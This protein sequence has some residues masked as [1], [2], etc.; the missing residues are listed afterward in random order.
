MWSWVD[1]LRDLLLQTVHP[2]GHLGGRPTDLRL[3]WG[4]RTGL[5]LVL[6]WKYFRL[7]NISFPKIFQRR[8]V[9]CTV[10]Q[11]VR[12]T[13]GSEATTGGVRHSRDDFQH[14]EVAQTHSSQLCSAIKTQLSLWLCLY[15]IRKLA[16]AT[17]TFLISE[18]ECPTLTTG[19]LREHS[20]GRMGRPGLERRRTGTARLRTT[21]A[22]QVAQTEIFCLL[23]YYE[24]WNI[25]S[26]EIFW[27]MK[28]FEMWNIMRNEIFWEM[29]YYEKGNIMRNEIFWELKYFDNWNIVSN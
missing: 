13:P 16:W 3:H 1:A 23:K 20:P 24:K 4:R 15:G 19:W 17:P 14:S 26:N 22:L 9:W 21:P 5:R 12:R 2:E 29:K 18:V 10:W 6:R 25:M 27:E 7:E 11:G 28:Y 8:T